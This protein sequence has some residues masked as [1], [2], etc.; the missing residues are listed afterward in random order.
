MDTPPVVTQGRP[1]VIDLDQSDSNAIVTAARK[2][3]RGFVD[4]SLIHL[5]YH[6]SDHAVAVVWRLI[7]RC[8]T[9]Q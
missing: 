3:I 5:I 2:A 8:T 4:Y 7:T 6:G 1:F 9:P